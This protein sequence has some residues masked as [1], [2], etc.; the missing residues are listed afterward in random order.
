MVIDFGMASRFVSAFQTEESVKY[1][2]KYDR[3]LYTCPP[4]EQ[5]KIEN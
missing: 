2:L 4:T 5:G 3:Y 1:Y